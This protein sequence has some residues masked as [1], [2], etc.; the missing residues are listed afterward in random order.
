M[1]LKHRN[2]TRPWARP[3]RRTAVALAMAAVALG[4]SGCQKMPETGMYSSIQYTEAQLTTVANQTY[5]TATNYQNQTVSLGLDVYLPPDIGTPRPTIITVHGGGF[6]GGARTSMTGTAKGYARRGYA[7]V[8]ISYRIN[9]NAQSSEAL[10]LQT[11]LN[12]IDD[13]MEAVRWVKANAATYG[14]D[15]TRVAVVGSSAGGAIALGIGSADD[16]TPTGPLVAHSPKIAAA[17]STGAHL[18]PGIDNGMVT[19]EST[20]AA[21]LMFHYETDTVTNNTDEYAQRTC[22]GLVAAGVSCKMVVQAGSGHT[23]SV[24]AGSTY[25]QSEIGTFLWK[26]L[27]LFPPA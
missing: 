22:D 21:A 20:D 24:G 12:A 14:F 27:R 2:Q 17:V 25:W 10:Y 13:G 15:T 11:A 18:T 19:F 23:V 5:G 9:P 1:D 6:V 8:N 3:L 16:P 7:A 4:L 26:N